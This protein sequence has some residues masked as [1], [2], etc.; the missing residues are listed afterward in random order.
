MQ[1]SVARW[2]NSLAVRLPSAAAKSMGVD[3]GDVLLAEVAPNGG[4]LL[5][6]EARVVDRA[7]VRKLRRFLAGQALTEPVVVDMRRRTRY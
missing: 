1:L 5:A 7:A 6:P 4:L 2:G 3:E